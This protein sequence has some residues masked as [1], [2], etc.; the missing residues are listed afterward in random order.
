MT[1]R[2][3]LL[4][5]VY[6]TYSCVC[7]NFINPSKILDIF[8]KISTAKFWVNCLLEQSVIHSTQVQISIDS[9]WMATTRNIFT[10]SRSYRCVSIIGWFPVIICLIKGWEGGAFY[11]YESFVL[12]VKSPC[13]SSSF[14][15][16]H[17]S[18]MA[19]FRPNL[20]ASP[21]RA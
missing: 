2:Q 14:S 10:D 8:H 12:L 3:L 1:L 18:S 16:R 9:I 17:F 20:V 13:S 21:F 5:F 15:L 11:L 7:Y 4:F 19:S 6:L